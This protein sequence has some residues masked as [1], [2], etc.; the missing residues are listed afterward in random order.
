MRP[1]I[2]QAAR[3][4]VLEVLDSGYLTEG[5]VTRDLESAVAAFTGAGRALAVTNCTVGL[6]LA[7]RALDAGPGAKV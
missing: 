7:L 2:P 4:K 5:P 6:E 1:Y 3:D